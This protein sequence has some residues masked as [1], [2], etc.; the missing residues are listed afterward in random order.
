M[1][2]RI[3]NLTAR[4]TFELQAYL[5]PITRELGCLGVGRQDAGPMQ[6]NGAS[7]ESIETRWASLREKYEHQSELSK[8]VEELIDTLR[9]AD[10]A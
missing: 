5:A 8:F 10:A 4:Q 1:V 7:V 2:K 3:Q 9:N 6:G